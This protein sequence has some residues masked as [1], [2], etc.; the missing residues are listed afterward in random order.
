[1]H[2]SFFQEGNKKGRRGRA[3]RERVRGFLGFDR[4]S[5]VYLDI[6]QKTAFVSKETLVVNNEANFVRVR[7]FLLFVHLKNGNKGI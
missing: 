4:F 2:L 6:S 1:M 7:D 3:K 5:I